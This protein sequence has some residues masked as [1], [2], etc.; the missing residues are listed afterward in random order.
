MPIINLLQA[1]EQDKLS[2]FCLTDEEILHT[3]KSEDVSSWQEKEPKYD[4]SETT[5]LNKEG[6]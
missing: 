2:K 6:K 4:F 3:L 5:A 1:Y